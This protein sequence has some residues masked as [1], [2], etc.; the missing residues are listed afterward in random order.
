MR[1]F[2]PLFS[3]VYLASPYISRRHVVEGKVLARGIAG[4]IYFTNG[5]TGRILICQ[6]EER[7]VSSRTVIARDMILLAGTIVPRARRVYAAGIFQVYYLRE[8]TTINPR[9]SR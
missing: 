1:A 5:I 6:S 8:I 2:N 3:S 9:Q 4:G 7:A